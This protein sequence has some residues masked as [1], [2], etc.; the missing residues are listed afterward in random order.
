M[1]AEAVPTVAR[2]MCV[3][4]KE[5][6]DWPV[7]V[8]G[9]EQNSGPGW[10]AYAC[11]ACAHH[12]RTADDLGAALVTHAVHCKVCAAA[13]ADCATAEALRE[14]HGAAAEAGR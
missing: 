7:I 1:T 3:D 12:Y 8:G 11:P 13:G 5:M 10:I 14:A 2:R 4:C 6:T 9:V